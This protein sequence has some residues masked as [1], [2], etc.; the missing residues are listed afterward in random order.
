MAP[1]QLDQ[2]AE[3]QVEE[4]TQRRQPPMVAL[5]GLL[6]LMFQQETEAPLAALT[7]MVEMQ[8]TW[9]SCQSIQAAEAEEA[10]LLQAT[11]VMGEQAATTV[12]VVVVAALH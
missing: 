3:E 8:K 2:V 12:E 9:L 4:L 5:V 6:L 11:E 1:E 7:I 10:L